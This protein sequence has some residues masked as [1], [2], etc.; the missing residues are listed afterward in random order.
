MQ[1]SVS[2]MTDARGSG[3]P[4]AGFTGEPAAG[5]LPPANGADETCRDERNRSSR[6]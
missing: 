1:R 2:R 6:T 3:V 5:V 4:K